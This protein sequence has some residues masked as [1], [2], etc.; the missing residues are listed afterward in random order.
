MKIDY[1]LISKFEGGQRL[2]G[3][4]PMRK[5]EVIGNSGVT[6]GTG[7]DVGQMS[8]GEIC[9]LPISETLKEK[10]LP[11][12]NI[13]K[14]AAK[15]KLDYT[16]L[17][18]TKP[19]ADELDRAVYE[20]ILN[21]LVYLYNRESAVKFDELPEKAQTCIASIAINMGPAFKNK[22]RLLWDLAVNHEWQ[23]LRIYLSDYPVKENQR[24]LK[25]RRMREGALLNGL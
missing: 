6:I 14:D 23:E 24:E 17:Y 18:I 16:P 4:I 9:A 19:E 8:K 22:D 1:A 15:A 7:V 13:V 20:K 12:G 21:I 3:Y 2:E 11:F 25:K 5:G 10:L